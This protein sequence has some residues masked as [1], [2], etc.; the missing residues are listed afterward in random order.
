MLIALEW[1]GAIIA[2]PAI[3][4]GAMYVLGEIFGVGGQSY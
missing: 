2:V 3:F 1:I 4:V